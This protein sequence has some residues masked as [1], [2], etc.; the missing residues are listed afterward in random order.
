MVH[1]WSL[2][3]F[4]RLYCHEGQQE[5]ID[6][7][8]Q[9]FHEIQSVPRYIYYDNLRA[10]YDYSRKKFQDSYLQF[11]SHY[12]YSHEVCNPVSPH[13]KGTEEESVSYIRRNAFG[14]RNSFDS[15]EDAQQWLIASL[16]R[17]YYSV[18]DTYRQKRILLKI[19]E[20][21]I[22]LVSGLELIASHRRLQGKGQYSLNIC[23]YLK[24]FGGKPGSL[25]HSKGIQQAPDSLQNLYK[26]HYLD[27]PLDFSQVL[28]LTGECSVH[29]LVA[30][31]EKL[32]KNH[33]PPEYATIRMFLNNTPYPVIESLEGYDLI[34]VP[35]PDLTV[36]DG[37][38]ECAA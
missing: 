22:D 4:A 27:R 35:V 31:I 26:S 2:F 16:D 34:D 19:Y 24:T 12:G 10:V 15:I 18:P 25:R 11:A 28:S 20:G 6:A 33:I 8:I 30:A 13:E 36:Y 5:V 3:R 38:S 9:F 21:R 37:I 29:E 17:N 23:H 1:T 7:H 14:E 32:Q